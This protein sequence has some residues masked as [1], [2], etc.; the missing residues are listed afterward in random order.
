MVRICIIVHLMSAINKLIINDY[1]NKF[2]RDKRLE[3]IGGKGRGKYTIMYVCQRR[4]TSGRAVPKS[5]EEIQQIDP[6]H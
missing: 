3:K 6:I 2:A 4:N 1:N 5:F